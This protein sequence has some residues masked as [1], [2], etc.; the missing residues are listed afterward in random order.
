[1]ANETD[2]KQC[3]LI[4]GHVPPQIRAK[5]PMRQVKFLMDRGADETGIEK[6]V[7]KFLKENCNIKVHDIKFTASPCNPDRNSWQLWS[8]MIDFET[9]V[10]M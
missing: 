1:M 5:I 8:V 6:K 7:N 4:K 10:E 9:E 3:A 2:K